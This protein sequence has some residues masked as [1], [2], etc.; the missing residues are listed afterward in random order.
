[1]K[2]PACVLVALALI[3]WSAA[4]SGECASLFGPG[5][6]WDGAD[7]DGASS[8]VRKNPKNKPLHQV[9]ALL[10]WISLEVSSHLFDSLFLTE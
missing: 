6:T 2:F 5:E 1:M 9:P 10:A 8:L 7:A 4:Q 3:R